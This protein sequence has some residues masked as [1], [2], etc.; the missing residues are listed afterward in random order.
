MIVDTYIDAR[1]IEQLL[2][3][4]VCMPAVV[5]LQIRTMKSA[6]HHSHKGAGMKKAVVVAVMVIIVVV[7]AIPFASGLIME[8]TVRRAFKDVNSIYAA[9][10]IDYSLEIIDYKRGWLT[11]D[12]EWKID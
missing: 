3:H 11:S 1:Y 2:L 8:R 6:K 7:L 10:G 5:N 9:S 4:V 12:I